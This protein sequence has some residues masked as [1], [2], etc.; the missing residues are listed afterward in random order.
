MVMCRAGGVLQRVAP[1]REVHSAVTV[2]TSAMGRIIRRE[3]TVLIRVTRRVYSIGRGQAL[4]SILWADL[5][6]AGRIPGVGT[7]SVSGTEP[8]TRFRDHPVFTKHQVKK[9]S[10]SQVICDTCPIDPQPLGPCLA[11]RARHRVCGASLSV[12]AGC[13]HLPHC[14]DPRSA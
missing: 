11:R 13:L 8:V 1:G 2:V 4:V 14:I 12:H 7:P 3:T 10:Q 6:G 5:I 9:E